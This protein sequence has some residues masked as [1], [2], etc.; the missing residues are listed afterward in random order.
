MRSKVGLTGSIV[1]RVV[2]CALAG[3]LV[4]VLVPSAPLAQGQLPVPSAHPY[5]V[6]LPMVSRPFRVFVPLFLSSTSTSSSALRPQPP[7]QGSPP[8]MPAGAAP[9]RRPFPTGFVTRC[10]ENLQLDGQPYT[11]V[12]TN[13]SYLAGP[14][15]PEDKM[16]EVVSFLAGTGVEVIR[17]WVEPGCDLDRV[18]RMLDLGCK[19]GVRFIL[20]LQDFFGEKDGYWFKAKYVTKDLPHISNIVPR[21][22]NRPEVLMWEL[23]NEPTCP[24]KDSNRSC[25]DALYHWAQVTSEAVKQLDPNHLV[26]LGTYRAGFEDLAIDTFRR[27]HALDTVDIVSV[28]CTAGKVSKGER[29]RERDIAHKLAKPIYFGEVY[30][31]AYDRNCQLLSGGVLD[32]RAKAVATDIRDSWKAGIDGYLL[33]QYIHDGCGVTDYLRADPVWAVI[34]AIR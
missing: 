22:A 18:E 15:F 23:M 7:T 9:L 34:K 21:F 12:G 5:R 14:Y 30:M 32:R 20:T 29:Q 10:G 6:Y 1:Q 27:A 24:P 3:L 31:L 11:F 19:Y 26:S 33:W 13:V 2:P 17:V 28:H 25:W 16:E 4:I 8:P